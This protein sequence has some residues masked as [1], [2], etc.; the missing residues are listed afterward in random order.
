MPASGPR[1]RRH[2]AGTPDL[3]GVYITEIPS[4]SRT[5]TGVATSITAFVGR[6]LRGP[7]GEP[8]TIFTYT[9]FARVFGDLWKLSGLG[10]AVRDFY[11]NGGGEALIVRIA[12]DSGMASLDVGG[13]TLAASG[14]G[15]WGN[16]LTASVAHPDPEDPSIKDVADT[17]GV[18][19]ADLFHLTL[20]G[21][22]TEEKYLNVTVAEG[23]R[24]V[25]LV[26]ASSALP[27]ASWNSYARW[28]PPSGTGRP[29][30]TTGGSPGGRRAGSARRRCSPGRAGQERPWPPR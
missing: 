11:L 4:G 14:P 29:S 21:G 10:Y 7:A 19:P 27:P 22:V 30:W 15:A 3:S 28:S 24:Q 9:D 16:N 23:P 18:E 8:V 13:L 12:P 6:A 26:L 1:R 20:G 17:Q 5:V 25:D 2:H